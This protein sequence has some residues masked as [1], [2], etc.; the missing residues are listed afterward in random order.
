MSIVNWVVVGVGDIATKRVIPAIQEEPSSKLYGVVSRSAEKADPYGC[1]HWADLDGALAD[2]AVDAVYLATPVA[3]HAPQ[4]V[5][6]LNASKHVLCE[7]PVALRYDD[8]RLMAAAA[9]NAEKLLGIAYY[10]RTYPKVHR[11]MDLLREG[12]IGKPVLAEINCHDWFQNEDGF[13]AWLLDP[14]MSGGGPLFDIASHRIDLLNFVFGK[15]VRV[16]GQRSNTVHGYPVEDSATV[17]IEY[18]S[19]VRGIVDVRWHSR[20]SRDEFRIVGTEGDIVLSPLN[21]PRLVHPGGEEQIPNHPN[22]HLPCIAN[23]V[24]A[25]NEGTPLLSSGETAMVTD[26]V[27][28]QVTRLGPPQRYVNMGE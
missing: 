20:V 21:G 10:R 4:T 12:A 11:A 25:V 23:F 18:E 24:A 5:A 3:L 26:W 16:T 8:A 6:A 7:K 17:L 14:S 9:R 2:P 13:R 19:G 15:P 27:T 28:E 1:K 22:L